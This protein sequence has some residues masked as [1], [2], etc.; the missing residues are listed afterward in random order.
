MLISESVAVDRSFEQLKASLQHYMGLVVE[1]S[2]QVDHLLSVIF[3]VLARNT[4]AIG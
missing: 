3:D 2:A 1:I 4:D